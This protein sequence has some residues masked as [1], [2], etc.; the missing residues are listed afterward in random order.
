MLRAWMRAVTLVAALMMLCG[1]TTGGAA[2]RAKARAAKSSSG[3]RAQ[4]VARAAVALQ[5]LGL[6]HGDTSGKW[7][8]ELHEAVQTFQKSHDLK[9]TGR[10]N[11]E[12][13]LAL[14]LEGG[15]PAAGG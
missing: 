4:L 5:K 1:A 3:S 12:T 6:Y 9:T 8:R 10:L 14:G 2:P 11:K 7:S 13:R 15:A